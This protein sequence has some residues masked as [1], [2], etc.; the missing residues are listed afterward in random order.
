MF[1]SGIVKCKFSFSFS[2]R[3][4]NSLYFTITTLNTL[5]L[6]S[7]FSHCVRKAH[8]SLTFIFY[9]LS[10]FYYFDFQHEINFMFVCVCVNF[11]FAFFYWFQKKN[12]NFIFAKRMGELKL[13]CLQQEKRLQAENMSCMREK[14]LHTAF[15][16]RVRILVRS[17]C[18][19]IHIKTHTFS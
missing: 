8:C 17:E 18:T 1:P 15:Y 6:I 9:F 4:L 2:I 13:S 10:L 16:V 12:Q 11:L 7:Y 19:H 5:F 3:N 14:N